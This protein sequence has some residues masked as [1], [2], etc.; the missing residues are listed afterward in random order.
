M[1]IAP[2]GARLWR[3]PAVAVDAA[4]DNSRTTHPASACIEAC[5]AF[6]E[7]ICVLMSGQNKASALQ[8]LVAFQFTHPALKEKFTRSRALNL[9]NKDNS[10]IVSSGWVVHTLE[11]ALWGFFAYDTWEEGAL[12]VVNLGE[13]SDTVGAVYGALAGVYYGY[14]AIPERW[15]SRM[16]NAEPIKDIATNFA[17]VV[18]QASEK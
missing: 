11:A 1:R 2:I 16:Q 10:K 15:V 14:E 18:S 3:D 13:D 17:T 9:R 6:T 4:R 5:Q 7:M 8:K 12:A